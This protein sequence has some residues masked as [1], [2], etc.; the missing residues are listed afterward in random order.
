VVFPNLDGDLSLHERPDNLP[1]VL[2]G[3]IQLLLFEILAMNVE[4]DI[5]HNINMLQDLLQICKFIGDIIMC[6]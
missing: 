6:V 5:F 3:L 2:N 4:I 1:Y